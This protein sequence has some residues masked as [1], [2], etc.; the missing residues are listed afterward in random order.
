M[1]FFLRREKNRR[2]RRKTSRSKERTNNKLNPRMTRGPEIK[3]GPHWWPPLPPKYNKKFI[4]I[5]FY[6]TLF[7]MRE[8]AYHPFS[9]FIVFLC[10]GF[11]NKFMHAYLVSLL[12]GSSGHLRKIA[13]ALG[14]CFVLK[15]R[16][17][18]SQSNSTQ[19][20]K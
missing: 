4:H 15:T 6:V 1:L 20:S 11:A 12:A 5:A 17:S 16:V 10:H 8:A 3:P 2:T 9:F 19:N 7:L 14:M 13:A 18:S